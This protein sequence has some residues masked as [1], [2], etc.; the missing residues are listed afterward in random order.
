VVT[1]ER[2]VCRYD[3]VGL[4]TSRATGKLIHNDALPLGTPEHTVDPVSASD[5]A[6]ARQSL[7][8]LKLTAEEFLAH[9]GAVAHPLSE[10]PWAARLAAAVKSLA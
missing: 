6:D 2:V 7:G 9:H 10:C 5:Y 1:D 8:T 4:T 3:G